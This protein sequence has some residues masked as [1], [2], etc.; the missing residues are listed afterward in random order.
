MTTL[1]G[2]TKVGEGSVLGP[3]TRIT[4][5]SVGRGATVDSS[6]LVEARVGDG[7]N[8]GPVS[9]LRPGAILESKAKAGTCVEIKNSVV[10]EGSKVPHLSYIGD[11]TI[12][13]GA[14]IGA[15]TITCNYDGFRKHATVIGDGAFV[16][17][18]T[19]LVAPVCIG[20]GAVT[21]A[22]SAITRD[23]PDGALAVERTEQRTVEGFAERRRAANENRGE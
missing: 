10:G 11:A 4:D 19:M 16:G 5:S 3:N 8:V 15:G 20:T 9:Y 1:M 2:A 23:V 21:G 18:D 12:G 13:A 14:N 17:S 6:I 7:A 22:G